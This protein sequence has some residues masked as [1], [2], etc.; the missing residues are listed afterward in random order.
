M[1]N[2]DVHTLFKKSSTTY[3]YSSIFFPPDI[4]QDVFVLYNFVRKADNFVDAVPQQK[5]EFY[6]FRDLFQKALKGNDVDDNTITSF[7]ALLKRRNFD[8]KWITAFLDAMESDLHKN[9]YKTIE[10]TE[11]YMY[12]SAEVIGLMMARIMS[13]PK[14][15]FNAARMLG[16]SM[17][18]IN[19][20]R[21]IQED[22]DLGRTYLPENE[23]KKFKL[24]SLRN[25]DVSKQTQAF[26][27]FMLQQINYY[28]KWQEEAEKGFTYIPK[29]YRVPIKTASD[30]YTWTAKVIANDPF[31][32]YR[33]KVKPSKS[34]VITRALYN[35]IT[36]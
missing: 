24:K 20:I 4:K 10:E 16:K 12:G 23:I 31:I 9:I 17:Q 22:L 28:Y 29:R 30:M 5:K 13:L 21:D 14:E 7:V 15:S 2:P 11:K 25:D 32:V 6:T 19:F 36:A 26:K 35:Y 8:E 34:K 18:Y 1:I 3:F 33:K 27:D